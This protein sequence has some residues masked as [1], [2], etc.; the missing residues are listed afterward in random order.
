MHS[1]NSLMH[2]WILPEL[3]EVRSEVLDL[4]DEIDEMRY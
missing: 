3:P 2:M 1:R 4:A